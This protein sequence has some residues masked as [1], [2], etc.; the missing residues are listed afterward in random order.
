MK[1]ALYSLPVVAL[2]LFCHT[3]SA[4]I[5]AQ[6]G[7]GTSSGTNHNPIYRASSTSTADYSRGSIV[8]S[9]EELQ[10]QGIGFNAVI[11]KAFFNKK[12]NGGTN[13][14]GV[15]RIY[16]KNS[17]Q[18]ALSNTAPASD[19]VN[20]I[21][22]ATM[23]YEK[24]TQTIDT[25]VGWKQFQLNTPF[26]YTGNSLEVSFEWDIS[27]VAGNASTASFTWEYTTGFAAQAIG[28]NSTSALPASLTSTASKQRPNTRFEFTPAYADEAA[29]VSID[30]P[31]FLNTVASHPVYVHFQNLGSATLTGLNISYA[32]NG[33][34]VT[35][36]PWTGSV[37]PT[38]S[39]LAVNIGNVNIP[40]GNSTLQVWI[41]D[42]NGSADPYTL[43]DTLSIPLFA[44]NPM[45]GT[46][47]LNSAL[48]A[49]PTNFVSYSAL[50]YQLHNCGVS[51]PVIINAAGGGTFTEQP[52]FSYIPGSSPVNTI[53]INANNDT[54]QFD[55]PTTPRYIMQFDSVQYVTVNNI[56]VRSTGITYGWGMQ[57]L[58][59]CHYN[60]FNNITVDVRSITSTTAANSACVVGSN[61]TT[62][63]TTD[64][65]NINY[66]NFNHSRFM[67]GYYAIVLNGIAANLVKNV[68][69]DSCVV[70]DF[71]LYGVYCDK[72]DSLWVR[73]NDINRVSDTTISSF[74]GVYLTSAPT[75]NARIE[76]NRIHDTHTGNATSTGVGYGIYLTS[77]DAD[78]GTEN[79]V[80]NNILYNFNGLSGTQYGIYSSSNYSMAYNNSINLDYQ[81]S[82]AGTAVGLY[83]STAVQGMDYRNNVVKVTRSGTGNK[84]G[85]Y[86]A[87]AGAL[88]T[89][90]RNSYFVS[91]TGGTSNVGYV[92]ATNYSTLALWQ[93][94]NGN[95]Y[96]TLSVYAN[97][98][99]TNPSAGDLTP[100]NGVIN[101]IG[102][103]NTGLTYDITGAIRGALPDPGAFEFTPAPL[104]LSVTQ[105]VSPV[106]GGCFTST[107]TVTV[108]IQ[109]AG[110]GT[111]DFSIDTITVRVNVSGAATASYD[112][113]ITAGTLGVGDTMLVTYPA[114]LDMTAFGTYNFVATIHSTM[115]VNAA[116]DTLIPNA[117]VND[118]LDFIPNEVKF[119]GFTG[120]N[121]TTFFPDWREATGV[122]PTGTTSTWTSQT[123]LGVTG[124]VTARINLLGTTKRDW[125]LGPKFIPVATDS[126]EFYAAVTNGA[127]TTVGDAMGSDD[128][129]KVMVTTDCGVS[130]QPIFAVTAANALPITLTKFKVDL[131]AYA[132]QPIRVAFMATDGPVDDVESYDFHLDSIF[133]GT[134]PLTDAGIIAFTKPVRQCADS[135][136][137]V[138]V[139][140]NNFGVG[141]LTNLSVQVDISG[142]NT[143][144]LN[145]VMP[146]LGAGTSDTLSLGFFNSTPGGSFNL[147]A[148]PVLTGDQQNEND[149]L[150]YSV[151]IDSVPVTV[152]IADDTICAGE[153]VTLT[154]S[155][156]LGTIKWFDDNNVQL[157]LAN[158]LTVAPATTTTYSYEATGSSGSTAGK[159]APAAAASFIGD[160]WGLQFTANDNVVINDV[161]M[162]YSSTTG[163]SFYIILRNSSNVG[164]DTAL[165]NVPAGFNN[166]S[167]QG[168]PI[169]IPLNFSIPAG[170]NYRLV[171]DGEN[172]LTNLQRDLGSNGFPIVSPGGQI[173]I[174]SGWTGTG[175][176]TAYYFFYNWQITVEGCPGERKYVTVEVGTTPT[177][178]FTVNPVCEGQA[179]AITDLSTNLDAG[180]LYNID[181]FNDNVIDLVVPQGD[182]SI[183]SPTAGTIPFSIYAT[184]NSGCADTFQAAAVINA[185]PVAAFTID[186]ACLGT[187]NNIT[188]L[189]T[190]TVGALYS[191]QENGS[192][193]HAW[194][195]GNTTYTYATVGSHAPIAI[196]TNNTGCADTATLSTE[197]FAVP[198]VTANDTTV[199]EGAT[200]E[201]SANGAAS[202]VWSTGDNTAAISVSPVSNTSY[203]VTGSDANGC[204]NT[205]TSQVTV[206]ALPIVA[207]GADI[208]VCDQTEVT[209][210]ATGASTYVWCSGETTDT[211]IVTA[212]GVTDICLTGT[213]ANGCINTDTV[214]VTG[215]ALP[216]LVTTN[217]TAL[218]IGNGATLEVTGAA[219]YEWNGGETTT[220][221][222]VNPVNTTTYTVTGTD[223]N[224]CV[225]SAE[226]MVTVNALPAIS[227]TG[228]AELCAG[229]T[230]T[231]T[232]NGG[233]S[234]V[235]SDNSTNTTLSVTPA[236]ST[237]YAVTGTDA[238]GCADTSSVQVIVNALP[239]ATL[240]ALD[241]MC[242]DETA[243]TLA[244][245]PAGG[246]FTGTGVSGTVFDPALAGNGN[247]AITYTYTDGNG[248]VDTD[249]K[250]VTVVNCNG[251]EEIK[252]LGQVTV[253][254]N[255]FT[256]NL[257]VS[258]T[259]TASVKLTLQLFDATGRLVLTQ[260]N[261]VSNGS[262]LITLN[263]DEALSAG[264]YVLRISDEQFKSA[265]VTLLKQ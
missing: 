65:F 7:F 150:T 131:G 39:S 38:D 129:V 247:F 59:N 174:T 35:T 178:N 31:V 203:T 72:S 263:T 248:C 232:G 137:E 103:P 199:C 107:E 195:S 183:L 139:I 240:N 233:T 54:V 142:V 207:A 159:P 141:D 29:L 239:T 85:I 138:E 259:A 10:A 260:V 69:I 169:T 188:N 75:R 89:A 226:V 208:S 1:K 42:P 222:S 209:L 147:K 242:D 123:N 68:K 165:V 135:L 166:Y 32:I 133:L 154:S 112:T 238:N 96:D 173:S 204:S 192:T 219:T 164:L 255:P 160:D 153:S 136:T 252:G 176:T 46:Y 202:Y 245:A 33:G 2:I 250:T 143:A 108:K 16:M 57:F 191:L 186:S 120:A 58:N 210:V 161:K 60:N 223:G 63:S 40:V 53:T 92:N 97:P 18:T 244:G 93:T 253:F 140:V 95:A 229:E 49:S 126:M 91:S 70:S 221:I 189:S 4:Q 30:S 118:T 14:P 181:L 145:A 90:N 86:I 234:Y 22:G 213:D 61:S 88:V 215:F 114:P 36:F 66:T 216:V 152:Q 227:I 130:W 83:V 127:S 116:N 128:S 258:I 28:N 47:T 157:A 205:Y 121:L 264:T 3:L 217:D 256:N 24:L 41:S 179:T 230:A 225:D 87:T 177:L 119:N 27:S 190:G 15:F 34:A 236:A 198:T 187:P 77:A 11:Y 162:F 201:L 125:L 71:Y 17:S 110:G 155:N 265:T 84:H 76:G 197:I 163:G 200:A 56:Y 134:R 241:T 257:N 167:P 6:I 52:A 243:I 117:R 80:F 196:V 220:T 102:D 51:G 111:I 67:G 8:F 101:N 132:G 25:A 74:Y 158:S 168:P 98:N 228:D 149:T 62:S 261:G 122:I 175:T 218:C 206:N 146:F 105:L 48:P 43:N 214:T 212:N 184:N 235:W 23:V 73:G 171:I 5:I 172:G 109:N 45:S 26:Q 148:Y 81:G 249:V 156:P 124:N 55:P 82:T 20:V 246:V 50:A 254:P 104:D 182:T 106:T 19:W 21:G 64:G 237:A 13:G 9:K 100:T 170:V 194:A 193:I 231:L 94:A 37:L 144:T 113:V 99:F 151:N 12:N 180:V 79:R 262:N 224:G 78:P 185:N 251:I 211:L 44:C 115:D